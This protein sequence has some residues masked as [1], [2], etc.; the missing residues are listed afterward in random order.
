[1]S[2]TRTPYL[3]SGLHQDPNENTLLAFTHPD[4]EA[5]TCDD[6]RCVAGILKMS[7]SQIAGFVGVDSRTVRKW[8]S[9]P[10]ASTH[11]QIPYAPWRLML[12]KANLIDIP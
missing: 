7:G 12:I 1:M 8:M 6:V 4:F 9:P 3:V 2:E 11:H 5:P 10:S